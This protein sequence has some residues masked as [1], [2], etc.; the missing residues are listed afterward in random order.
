MPEESKPTFQLDEAE[1]LAAICLLFGLRHNEAQI[2]LSLMTHGFRTHDQLRAVTAQEI[3]PTSTM[4]VTLHTLRRKL[5]PHDIKII[6]ISKVGFT[7]DTQARDKICALL[8]EHGAGIVPVRSKP[9]ADAA[10]KE[11]G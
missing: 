4:S 2:L 7:I 6:N 1:A 3:V 9:K 10:L 5:Q 11:Y 8:V